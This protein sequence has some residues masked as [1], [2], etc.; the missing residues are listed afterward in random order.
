MINLFDYYSHLFPKGIGL[1][2]ARILAATNEW[3]IIFACRSIERGQQAIKTITKGSE[4]IQLYQLDLSDL[5]SVKS[6]AKQWG[7]QPIDCLALNAGISA[8]NKIPSYSAQGYESTIATN[9]IGHFYLMNL[10]LSNV[11][12]SKNGRIVIVGSNGIILIYNIS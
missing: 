12:K 6:F 8:S 9:H 7:S 1:S 4:N 3:N 10:L 11:H 5:N 2:A